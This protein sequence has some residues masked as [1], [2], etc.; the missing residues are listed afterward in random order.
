[1]KCK[2]LLSVLLT[3]LLTFTALPERYV[4]M[5]QEDE[6]GTVVIQ[7]TEETEVS[8]VSE[9]ITETDNTQD[10]EPDSFDETDL[11][12][13]EEETVI[14]PDVT[15]EA[16]SGT[17]N[18]VGEIF[19]NWINKSEQDSDARETSLKSYPL[20]SH[21]LSYYEGS[22]RVRYLKGG[23]ENGPNYLVYRDS[24]L[25]LSEEDGK[26]YELLFSKDATIAYITPAISAEEL[27][28]KSGIV[29][30][31]ENV[32]YD[33]ILVF[34]QAPVNEG[35]RLA[36]SLKETEKISVNEVFSDGRLVV[37]DAK[38]AST[39]AGVS[40]DTNPSGTNWSGEI[41]N[42]G[43]EWPSAGCGVDIWKL[44]FYLYLS[45]EFHVDFDITTQGSS[46]GKETRKLAKLSFPVEIF[47]ISMSYNVQAD[48]DDTPI[49]VKGTMTTS[50]DYSLSTRGAD[51][52]NYKTS[53]SIKQLDVLRDGDCNKDIK[54]YIGSQI[55]VQG[56]FISLELDLGITSFELGPV[57][58]LNQDSR[59]G[60]YF[61]ARLEKDLLHEGEIYGQEVHTCTKEGEEGCLRLESREIYQHRIFFKIDL[62]FDDWDLNFT[63]SDEQT[64]GTKQFYD[65]HTF[66]SGMKEGVC[67]HRFYKVP[68]AV[69][70]DDYMTR[71]APNITV[72]VSDHPDILESEKSLIEAVTDSNGKAALYLPYK[73]EY[74][75]TMVSSGTIDGQTLAGSQRMAHFIVMENNDQV[76]IILRSDETVTLATQIV[77][78][79]DTDG[80]DIPSGPY[81]QILVHAGRREAGSNDAWEQTVYHMYT[82]STIDWKVDDFVVPKFGFS[83][84]RAYLYEY[85]VRILVYNFENPSYTVITPEDGQYYIYYS[86][87]AYDD[88]AGQT[89][90]SH[91]N[92]YYISY[93][94]DRTEERLETVIHAKPV[95][96]VQLNKRWSLNDPDNKPD[97]VYLA[98]RQKPASGWEQKANEAGIPTEWTIIL[99]PIEGDA[100]SL[101]ALKDADVLTVRDDISRIE[102]TPLAIGEVDEENDWKLTYTVPKYRDGV[103]LQYEGHEL[104]SKIITDLFVYEYDLHTTATVKSFGDFQSI[105]GNA[106]GNGD[107]ELISDVYNTDPLDDNTIS[108]TIRWERNV[109]YQPTEYVTL[110]IKKNGETIQD[111][112]LYLQDFEDKWNWFWTLKLD[113]YDPQAEYTVTETIPYGAEGPVWVGVPHGL[114]LVN[115]VIIYEYVQCEAQAIFEREPENLNELQVQAKEKDS[116]VNQWSWNLQKNHGWWNRDW[117]T[118]KTEVKDISAYEMIAPDIPGYVKVYEEPYS[119]TRPGWHNLFYNFTVHYLLDSNHLKLHISKEWANT[120]ESTVY[121][122]EIEIEVFRN[123]EKIAETTLNYDGSQWSTAVISQDLDGN[124]LTRLDDHNRKYV[125]TIKEKAV[126]G[127]ES[128]VK[129]VSDEVD[130]LYYVITN[131]WV[132]ADY[133][134][135]SG[136]V[137]WEGDN[138]K[139]YL[140]PEYVKLSVINS[141]EEYV[142]TIVIPTNGDGSFETSNLPASDKHG[143]PLTY[144]VLESHVDGYVIRYSDPV[145]DEDTRTWICN[146]TNVLGNYYPITIRKVVEGEAD[147]ETYR[148]QIKSENDEANV[149]YAFPEPFVS[150]VSITGTGE[151]KAEF[152]IDEDGLYLYSI[153]E[154]KG[155][156]D[157]CIYDDSKQF[158][159]IARTT[160]D[161]GNAVYRSWV[162]EN[163]E[164]ID[165]SD[166][167]T[168]DTVTFTNVY[169]DMVIKKQWDTLNEDEETP[170]RVRA[171]V[172]R[173]DDDSWQTI[174]V[175]ELNE[176]N[177]W[178]TGVAIDGYDDEDAGLYRVREMDE[179]GNLVYDPATDGDVSDI[180]S[181]I[182]PMTEEADADLAAYEVSYQNEGNV[183]TITNSNKTSYSV[184]KTWDIDLGNQDH[185]DE[186]QVVLQK[187]EH[188]FSWKSVEILTLN[189][190]NNWSGDFRSV[191]KGF[192]ND[193]GTYEKYSYRI[194]ELEPA[195]E[196]AEEPADEEERL[197]QADKRVVYAMFDLDKPYL[198]NLI[199]QMD[200][201]NLWTLDFTTQWVMTQV[202]RSTIPVPTVVYHVDEYTDMIGKT[203]EEHETKY[204]VQYSHNSNTHVTDITNIAVLDVSIYKRWVNFE[205]E[206]MPES[207]YLMLVSKVQDD[208]AEA[209][210]VEEVNI[211]TPVFTALYGKRL[212]LFDVTNLNEL[213]GDGIK[214]LYGEN[215]FSTTVSTIVSKVVGR[216]AKTGIAVAEARGDGNNPFTKWRVSF[217][218]KKYGGFGVPM[219]FAGTELVTGLM[220]IALDAVIAETGA[221]I[222]IPVMYHP[223]DGYWSIKGYA[224]NLF[225]DY[226]LTCNVI[227]IK[228]SG[229]DE[230]ENNIG[231]T[232][233]WE[234]DNEEDRPDSVVLHVYVKDGDKEKTEVTGSPLTVKKEDD[235]K[236]SLEIPLAEL[237][238]VEKDG[239]ESATIRKKEIILEEEVPDGYMVRYED[240]DI[241]NYTY[242][243]TTDV[244]GK[245]I[246]DDQDNI[247]GKRPASITV[248]L[249]ADGTEIASKTVSAQDDW[250]WTFEDVPKYRRNNDG[251]EIEIVY[252]FSEDAVKDYGTTIA[253]DT[254][255]NH[256]ETVTIEGSKIWNDD[257]N[258]EGMRPESITIRL[259][260]D[261]KEVDSR[262]V[263]ADDGWSWKFENKPKFDNGKEIE[264]TIR[265]DAVRDYTT[266]VDGY[267]VTNSYSPGKTRIE[268]AKVW[269]DLDDKDEIRPDSVTIKLYADGE[270]TGKSLTLSE[271]NGWSG[272][273]SDLNLKK[274][275]K[276]ITYTIKEDE[277]DGYTTE[278]TGNREDGFVVT[279]KH[280]PEKIS[281]EGSKTWDDNDDQDGKRPESITIRLKADGKEVDSRTVTADDGW[282]WK[283]RVL[284]M[285]DDG[286]EIRYTIS[287]DAIEDY[288]TEIEGYNV[289]NTYTPGKTQIEVTKIWDDENDRDGIRPVSV[290]IR[291][292]ADGEDTG[293][294][295]VLSKDDGWTAFFKNLDLKKEENKISYTVREEKTDVITGTDGEGTYSFE[296]SGD[297]TKGY[298]ITNK[299]TPVRISIEGFKIWVDDDDA[300]GMRPES[301]TIRLKA[302]GKEADSR[303]VTGNDE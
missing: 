53:V 133:V 175:V 56:G 165:I 66:D 272:T 212:D 145:F 183:Y 141:K 297:A 217:G 209:A 185:P 172:Q 142:K 180:P 231:G 257:N 121:P 12:E 105:P 38:G 245:K 171:A 233:Y 51:I 49:R 238:V 253:G 160:D 242:S 167:N 64:V 130:D 273:F 62:F 59:G 22:L 285:D 265:E 275:G 251:E 277:V 45:L 72:T 90:Q 124:D 198:Q 10:G 63:N 140:R 280:T 224:L 300:E 106:S 188:I 42:F 85:R 108:G 135:L 37:D 119:Y 125:Y 149:L 126:D 159:L 148:F 293:K 24:F 199:K 134:K 298:T 264:Y 27:K 219:E 186:I 239:E 189:A 193:T 86:V 205:D 94:E 274:S 82:D 116:S 168:S 170:Y 215:F 157:R 279:N 250:K 97:S 158:I 161:N 14:V 80:K 254:I 181:I 197:A 26:A 143:N 129:L 225:E 8:G 61:T 240:Y 174:Q 48:F 203:I 43:A 34:D 282:S 123:D 286:K 46:S 155:D 3:V 57:L 36:V 114:D 262:T 263:T 118:L 113:D 115:Y 98:L 292:Y 179:D 128:A 29:F 95:V 227:N 103:K 208:Y 89:E 201:D 247:A 207:V 132:G 131:S 25:I 222:S 166:E 211:Y 120:D 299:H 150:P 259:K 284:P 81:S 76:N 88:A 83:G 196:D 182:L 230:V 178:K 190:A 74:R 52:D 2:R 65:S 33:D 6:E 192:I 17:S 281:I 258:A 70:F 301:I 60:C 30:L 16:V 79:A 87:D 302:D 228:F 112:N 84:D 206:E 47:E 67:P 44:G 32:G 39:K 117:Q 127:F 229:D 162:G 153:T 249:L 138:G 237:V 164:D 68:V 295:L 99:N 283:F 104:D 184:S 195:P 169:P 290:T 7:E 75:Y 50:F 194:R 268:V 221:A 96:D 91:T 291:L 260:A 187:K 58:S 223:I 236:W 287:E 151:T 266:T 235:W 218:V 256:F 303:T 267:D 248:R 35:D 288:T 246:W 152:L 77:W 200:P 220:E 177:G 19:A 78:E 1:M 137:N 278:I 294:T 156:N 244:S 214:A 243:G 109:Y 9:H 269:S 216:Y 154:I 163:D 213:V 92:K 111:L 54:F 296:V 147:L 28:G 110:H 191:V 15:V 271:G 232:K 11:T 270:D 18:I 210:G 204:Y 93:K 101:K 255:T 261:G 31:R 136:R 73:K 4:A 13:H 202:E 173:K 234:G 40:W 122:D 241:Y 252:T 226:E 41:S 102:N 144:S 20:E 146:V 21:E 71:P 276:E 107:Y 289:T 55:A 176:E 23:D 69:W 139:E 5:A 100:S